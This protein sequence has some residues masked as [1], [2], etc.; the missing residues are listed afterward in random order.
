[1]SEFIADTRY[2]KLIKL[3]H[4]SKNIIKEFGFLYFL[5][6]ATKE[7]RKQK[8]KLFAPNK[9]PRIFNK[10]FSEYDKYESLKKKHEI[11]KKKKLKLKANK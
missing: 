5:S 6:V 2:K 7:A 4:V 10:S 11:T 8:W 1:M 9:P 3:S